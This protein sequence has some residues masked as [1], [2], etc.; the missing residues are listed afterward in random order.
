[1]SKLRSTIRAKCGTDQKF[2]DAMG[3]SRSAM[4]LKLS[5]KRGWSTEQIRKARE[6]LDL[7]AEEAFE[8]FMGA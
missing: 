7:T 2:A 5:G 6:V 3:L 8:I 4:S 1:M